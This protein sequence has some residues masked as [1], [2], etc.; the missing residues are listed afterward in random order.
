MTLGLEGAAAFV[1]TPPRESVDDNARIETYKTFLR[2]KYADDLEGLQELIDELGAG[3]AGESVV[4]TQSVFEGGQASGQVTLEPMAK[5]K[6]ALDVQAELDPDV[7]E[8][9]PAPTRFADHSGGF[10]ET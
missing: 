6:A 4:I 8:D 5:L 3:A 7:A 9:E 10:L 1:L 2:R